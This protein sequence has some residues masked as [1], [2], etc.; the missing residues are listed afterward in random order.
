MELSCHAA[1]A[2]SRATIFK[3]PALTVAATPRRATTD[4]GDD[5]GSGGKTGSSSG[6][7]G[8]LTQ[9]NVAGFRFMVDTVMFVLK[10]TSMA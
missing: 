9:V 1:D 10:S 6:R 3:V 4:N 5:D 2:D 8:L 7:R